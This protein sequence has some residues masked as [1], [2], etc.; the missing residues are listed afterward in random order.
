MHTIL[1][2]LIRTLKPAKRSEGRQADPFAGFSSRDWADLPP[3][4]PVSDTNG[5]TRH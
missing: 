3:Y 4:H 2:T 5:E 1:N